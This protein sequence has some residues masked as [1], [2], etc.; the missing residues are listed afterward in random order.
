MIAMIGYL[1][2]KELG[3][4]ALFTPNLLLAWSILLVGAISNLLDRI[5]YHQVID[6]FL[7]G[8]AI[9]NLGDVLI[10]GGLVIYLFSLKT[11]GY[12]SQT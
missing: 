1:F 9:I 7:I 2:Y 11:K 3:K 4:K 12:V 8:T 5:I 10:V 6:Y